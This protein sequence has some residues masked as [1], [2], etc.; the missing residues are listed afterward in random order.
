MKDNAYPPEM[1]NVS[2]NMEKTG[3]NIKSLIK[4]SGYSVEEIMGFTGVSSPQAVYKWTSGK[5]IPSPENSLILSRL[6]GIRIEDL[7]VLDG[8]FD[9]E[10]PTVKRKTTT[11]EASS[12][13]HVFY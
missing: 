8:D 3:A 11:N 12:L 1:I 10:W 5:S 2:I 4:A 7:W 13:Q 6:L 9:I